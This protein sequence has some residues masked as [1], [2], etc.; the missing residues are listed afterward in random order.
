M[1]LAVVG[2][3]VRILVRDGICRDAAV[4]I[5][6]CGPT[7]RLVP[8]AAAALVGSDVGDEAVAA[9][10]AAVVEAA[11]PIDDVRGTRRHRLRVLTPLTRRV[12]A[13]ALERA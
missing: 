2:V 11:A 1:D 8:G 13:E 5:A 6:A 9:A 3:G 4:A 12:V 7:P 10:C